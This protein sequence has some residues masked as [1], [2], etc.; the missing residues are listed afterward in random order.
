MTPSVRSGCEVA[1]RNLKEKEKPPEITRPKRVLIWGEGPAGLR[2]LAYGLNLTVL[3]LN[4]GRARV[5]L[6]AD[7]IALRGEESSGR[8]NELWKTDFH[9]NIISF[10]VSFLVF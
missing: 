9:L 8:D 2:T 4:S 10:T 1:G 3:V 7:E 5:E 6:A